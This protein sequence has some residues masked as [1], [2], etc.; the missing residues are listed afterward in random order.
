MAEFAFKNLSLEFD[1]EVK[2]QKYGAEIGV[3]FKLLYGSIFLDETE[4]VFPKIQMLQHFLWPSIYQRHIF[5]AGSWK[6][7]T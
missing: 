3:K 7:K 1:G 5:C 4:T 6:T 2:T